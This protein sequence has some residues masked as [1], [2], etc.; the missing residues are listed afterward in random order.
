[1][2]VKSE[3]ALVIPVHNGRKFLPALL[4]SVAAQTATPQRVIV[5]DNGSTDGW[6]PEPRGDGLVPEVIRSETNLGFG[7]AGNLGLQR[8]LDGGADKVFVVNQ[9]V[10]LDPR[11]C[12]YAADALA[13]QPEYGLLVLLQVDYL[14]AALDPVFRN[15]LPPELIDDLCLGTPRDIYQV[16]FAPL[17]AFLVTRE[18]LA[19]VGGFDPLF[20]LYGEDNDYCRMAQLQGVRV[21]IAVRARARHWGGQAHAA[22][23]YRWRR[24]WVLSRA[25]LHLKW[26]PRPL[27]LA[28]LTFWRYLLGSGIR[29]LLPWAGA[30]VKALH[31]YPTLRSRRLQPVAAA[32]A[33]EPRPSGGKAQ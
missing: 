16:R 33:V 18:A 5:V 22:K 2:S 17:A 27:P 8:A 23:D 28:Y 15:Y 14:L 13:L 30:M 19:K 12:E 4:D 11:A 9:D 6:R 31:S 29:E 26:S 7:R 20:F 3:T 24:N 1:M 21:G 32:L 25:L 10:V